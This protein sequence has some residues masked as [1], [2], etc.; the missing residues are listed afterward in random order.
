MY[1]LKR[2]RIRRYHSKH[3]GISMNA[4][5]EI[6]TIESLAEA[7]LVVAAFDEAYLELISTNDKNIHPIVSAI[8][9]FAAA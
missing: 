2:F 7:I 4:W 9:I 6:F 3:S 8:P 1:K 5:S